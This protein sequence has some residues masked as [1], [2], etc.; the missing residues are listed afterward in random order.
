MHRQCGDCTACCTVLEVPEA[1]TGHYEKCQHDIGKCGIY[2][3][4]PTP[5]RSWRCGW[6][7][8]LLGEGDRPD[9]LGVMIDVTKD[10]DDPWIVLWELFEDAAETPKIR[11]LVAD[12]SAKKPIIIAYKDKRRAI[13]APEDVELKILKAVARNG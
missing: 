3:D 8:G 4:R 1:G 11:A 12:W 7:I 10:V 5:C 13:G 9:K 6:H 2:K